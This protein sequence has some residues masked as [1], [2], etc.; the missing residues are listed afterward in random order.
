M[1]QGENEGET[2]RDYQIVR[3]MR[4]VGTWNGTPLDLDV[5][6]GSARGDHAALLLQIDGTGPIVAATALAEPAS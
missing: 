6:A 5:A 1:L 2:A 4:A 3:S